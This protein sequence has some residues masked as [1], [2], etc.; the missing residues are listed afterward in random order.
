MTK[1]K[2][3]SSLKSNLIGDKLFYSRMFAIVIPIIIQNTI[4]NVVSL[5][6]NVMVGRVGTLEMSAV[7]N[8][9]AFDSPKKLKSSEIDWT[10]KYWMP[11]KEQIASTLKTK[12]SIPNGKSYCLINSCG[13]NFGYCMAYSV[14]NNIAVV[15]FETYGGE[16]VKQKIEE[17]LAKAPADHIIRQFT[18]GQ[19]KRN[20]NKWGW[21]IENQID[22]FDPNII[23]WYAETFVAIYSFLEPEVA[24]SLN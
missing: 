1:V 17:I 19:G 18:I 20:K 11:V 21:A 23:N 7:T 8:L 6:D 13:Q 4:T 2:S 22:K 9:K 3:G 14:R 15:A 16:V 5:L 12:M 24:K 10:G